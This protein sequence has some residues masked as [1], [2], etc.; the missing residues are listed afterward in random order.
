MIAKAR[1]SRIR[2]E[3]FARDGAATEG[4]APTGSTSTGGTGIGGSVRERGARARARR[5]PSRCQ[6]REKVAEYTAAFVESTRAVGISLEHG[7]GTADSEGGD[8]DGEHPDAR[9][10]RRRPSSTVTSGRAAAI[11]GGLLVLLAIPLLIALGVLTRPRWFPVLDMAQ[12]ELRVRDVASPHPPL[13]GLAGRIGPYGADGGSHPGPLSFYALWPFY[14]LFGSTSWALQTAG[15]ALNIAAMGVALW[16]AKRRGDWPLLL[17]VAAMLAVL[18]RAYGAELLT[19]PWNPYLPMLWWIVFVLAAWSLCC[20]DA[21][22]LPVVALAGSFCVQTH[23]SYAGL[24]AGVAAFALGVFVLLV[25]RA[26]AG[27]SFR[28]GAKKWA[29][30]AG[31]AAVVVWIPP[32]IDQV[33]HTPGNLSTIWDYFRAPPESAIGVHDGVHVLL[34]RLNPITLFTDTVLSK[35]AQA[36]VGGSVVPGVLLLGAWLV[37]VVVAWRLRISALVRLD[38]V[39]AVALVFGA[40]SAARI[41]G[42]V[43]YYLLL[44]AIGLAALLLLATGWAAAALLGVLL[45]RSRPHAIGHPAAVGIGAGLLGIVLVVSVARFGFEAAQVDVPSPAVNEALGRVVPPS[46]AGLERRQAQGERGPYLLTYLPDPI[47]IGGAGYALLDELDR[48]GFDVRLDEVNRPGAT[49]FRVMRPA[50]ANT[51]IHL[52]IGPDIARWAGDPR[53][54]QLASFDPRSPAE[55]VEFDRA[56]AEVLDALTAARKHELRQQVDA[57]AFMLA[58]DPDLPASTRALVTRM[59]ELGE[60]MAV[61]IGPPSGS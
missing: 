56:R 39:L 6:G 25:R 11:V 26:P 8:R 33:V 41:F 42:Y 55:R 57:N 46:V 58:L 38:A 28:R 27:G 30:V 17:G 4:A 21:V 36:P 43:W 50:D 54:Q 34:T 19:Q 24:I 12:T 29:I 7:A 3:C 14:R 5:A 44:W 52:A 23:I 51:E 45:D 60:P 20:A 59:L 13:I 15:V 35:G 47:G 16:I 49:R 2:S 32:V 53:Y 40:L 10:T 48:E 9:A 1:A 18:T 37:S 31:V 61:F 22:M